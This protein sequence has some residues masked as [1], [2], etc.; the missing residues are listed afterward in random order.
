[1]KRSYKVILISMFILIL[2]SS[3]VFAKDMPYLTTCGN[4][5]I[6]SETGEEVILRGY[7][8]GLWLSRSYWGLPIADLHNTNSEERYSPVNSVQMDYELFSNPNLFLTEIRKLENSA[9]VTVDLLNATGKKSL[10]EINKN[11]VVVYLNNTFYENQITELDI[12]EIAESGA[13]LVR[14]PL[15]WSF[16]MRPIYNPNGENIKSADYNNYGALVYRDTTLDTANDEDKDFLEHRMTYLENLVKWCNEYEIYVIFDIHVA[17]GGLND[18]GYRTGAHFFDKTKEGEEYRKCVLRIWEKIASTFLDNPTVFGYDLLNEPSNSCF[19]ETTK[20]TSVIDFY[21]NAYDMIS[22]MESAHKIKHVIIMEGKVESYS[23]SD[24][25]VKDKETNPIGYLPN[26]N[27][28]TKNPVVYSKH[29]YFFNFNNIGEDQNKT[30]EYQ[31]D[32]P[33]LD[34]MKARIDASIYETNIIKE[35]YNIPVWIGEFSCH[36][37]YYDLEGNTVGTFAYFDEEKQRVVRYGA[38]ALNKEATEEIWSYQIEQYEKNNISY[39]VWTYKAC[40]E[41]YFGINYM[42]GKLTRL[43][44]SNASFQEIE[45]LFKMPSE[46][47]LFINTNFKN[48]M[49]KHLRIFE[50][51]DISKNGKGTIIATLSND[52]KILTIH[53]EG[54]MADFS[55]NSLEP[56]SEYNPKNL[57]L[58]PWYVYSKNIEEVVIDGNITNIGVDAFLNCNQLTQ[59]TL[60]STIK[61]IGA[62]AFHNCESLGK[63]GLKLPSELMYINEGAFYNCKSLKYVELG[64]KV[65]YI[66][67]KVFNGCENLNDIF[68]YKSNKHFIGKEG[69]L[70]RRDNNTLVVEPQAK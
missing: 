63:D 13:N 27:C 26:P 18:G 30:E 41:N 46:K 8:L 35:R 58:P 56:M 7:N 37:Y 15:E 11:D 70:Y 66:G 69:V 10:Y 9:E 4:Q 22:N 14:V 23:N 24:V 67:D 43:D 59:I 44:I 57:T 5:I 3:N 25:K 64:S 39:A 2:A 50:G 62:Y 53:G 54:E 33:K 34:V 45:K 1:M 12:K 55:W 65:E 31:K 29:D 51:V 19:T 36:A 28:W 60:P 32:I 16:F 42:G 61:K 6:N 48:V 47:S 38:S 49:K 21:R 40:W 52:R 17:P 68:V 20:N